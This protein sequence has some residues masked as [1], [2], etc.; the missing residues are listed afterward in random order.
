MSL[1]AADVQLTQGCSVEALGGCQAE[2]PAPPH[3]PSAQRQGS[4]SLSAEAA[5]LLHAQR[6][7]RESVGVDELAASLLA[8]LVHGCLEILPAAGHGQAVHILH[9]G[10]LWMA[11][12]PGQACLGDHPVLKSLA[13]QSS[14]SVSETLRLTSCCPGHLLQAEDPVH[15]LPAL[16]QQALHMDTRPHCPPSTAQSTGYF[17]SAA[18]K[19]LRLTSVRQ[20]ARHASSVSNTELFVS[21]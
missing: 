3:A 18:P 15:C 10:V 9:A 4:E 16:R 21:K 17:V 6:A 7:R 1:T 14:H 19:E 13:C 8:G 2:G 12:A 20:A 5:G 11:R